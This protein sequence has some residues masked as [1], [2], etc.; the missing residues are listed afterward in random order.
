MIRPFLGRTGGP[1]K[2]PPQYLSG[3]Q[4][5]NPKDVGLGLKRSAGHCRDASWRLA[6][7]ALC[8]SAPIWS[9]SLAPADA[10]NHGEST[11]LLS[12]LV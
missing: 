6:R 2:V 11:F 9:A 8:E 10:T 7:R 4:E 3:E 5:A 12:L 1:S